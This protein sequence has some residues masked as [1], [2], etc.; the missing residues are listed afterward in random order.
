M[1]RR[2]RGQKREGG[3]W[4][5]RGRMEG[6][7]E[8]RVIVRGREGEWEKREKKICGLPHVSQCII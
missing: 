4:P 1:A 5:G 3:E 7:G 8:E 2:R 6:E